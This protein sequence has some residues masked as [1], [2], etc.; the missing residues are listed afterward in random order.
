MRIQP[1]CATL[2]WLTAAVGIAGLAARFFLP[3]PKSWFWADAWPVYVAAALISALL[4]VLA[5]LGWQCHR[6]RLIASMPPESTVRLLAQ[7]AEGD[8]WA[9]PPAEFN[10]YA[11]RLL[12]GPSFADLLTNPADYYSSLMSDGFIAIT[13]VTDVGN[14]PDGTPDT[15]VTIEL[16]PKARKALSDAQSNL[17]VQRTGARVARP[18]R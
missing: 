16:T 15:A 6:E 12:Y 10:T 13:S 9:G 2:P 4:L 5:Y 8:G 7:L 17:A 3:N 18:G 14:R 1:D 11:S